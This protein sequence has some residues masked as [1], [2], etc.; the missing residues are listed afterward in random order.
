MFMSQNP[1]VPFLKSTLTGTQLIPGKETAL[2]L[3]LKVS[4][5]ENETCEVLR[6]ILCPED[7]FSRL[8]THIIVKIKF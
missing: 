7:N 1:L 5:M 8:I 6:V 4:Q 2:T 3:T